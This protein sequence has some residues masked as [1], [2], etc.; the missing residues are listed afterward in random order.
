M[1]PTL[2][3]LPILILYPHSRCNCRCLMCD[4]WKTDTARELTLADLTRYGEDFAKLRLEWVVFSGGEPLMHSHLAPLCRFF[5]DRGIR[6]TLLT[7]GLLLARHAALVAEE[8]D[9]V[10]VSLDGPPSVHDRI[11]R[12]PGAYSALAAGINAVQRLRPSLPIS[13]RC[14]VQ[15]H[16][17][18]SLRLT[19]AAAHSL[20][21]VSISFLAADTHSTAFD[22]THGWDPT[23]RAEVAL[24]AGDLEALDSEIEALLAAWP[25]SSFLRESPAK[26]RAIAAHFRA[27]LGLAPPAAPRCNAPWVSAVLESTG[28]LR[29]CFFHPPLGDTTN[30]GFLNVLNSPEAAR[31][32]ASLHIPANPTC[33][34]CVCSLYRPTP[35]L[36]LQNAAKSMA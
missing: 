6:V 9:D 19:A 1:N 17:C 7:T 23:I 25:D 35:E 3:S 10:I 22:H 21:L 4:I 32:R 20:G 11:R 18:R 8:I 36:N 28:I 24:T 34:R 30:S 33:Q 16:N 12:V 27:A 13:A 31:F 15:R 14:T 26:L 5:R 2:Q 29:P